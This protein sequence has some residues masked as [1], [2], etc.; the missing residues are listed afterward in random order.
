MTLPLKALLV[1]LALLAVWAPVAGAF[2]LAVQDDRLA[3]S[4]RAADR[5]LLV[6]Q[7]Q[8]LHAATVRLNLDWGAWPA[9]QPA[10]DQA[11]A[12]LRRARL[13]VQLTL[14]GWAADSRRSPRA[15][16]R[17]V[18]K[19]GLRYRLRVARW[20]IWN[21]PNHPAFLSQRRP[22]VLY[23]RF[24][25][26]GWRALQRIDPVHPVLFGETS[27]S[28]KG[29]ATNPLQWLREV[30]CSDGRWR[31]K[32]RCKP[33]RA[34]GYAH[35]PYAFLTPPGQPTERAIGIAD[36]ERLR[37]PLRRLA[38]RGALVN[39]RGRP[40]PLYLTEFGYFRQ[41]VRGLKER[42]RAAWTAKTLA[43]LARQRQ[44]R[45]L[46]W[47]QLSAPAQRGPGVWDT[48]LLDADRSPTLTWQVLK[49]W[50]RRAAR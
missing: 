42:T 7:A 32:R 35:H 21:E 50:G 47:Y 33:L 1:S 30:T 13:R 43:L 10:V 46:L 41:G 9:Q 27:A 11:V 6:S 49:R 4:P 8:Q 39:R 15:F 29:A 37:V 36:L 14:T 40:L 22:G 28:G 3:Y 44:V 26:A 48:S 23:R 38:A 34:D 25:E 18:A 31:A 12:E 19:V 24:Y 45:Q 5:R 20:S 17:W 16:G 2:E